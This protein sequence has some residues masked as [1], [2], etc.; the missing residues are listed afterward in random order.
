MVK[1]FK[2]LFGH[3]SQNQLFSGSF[4]LMLGTTFANAGGYLYHLLMGRMLGPAGYGTLVSLIS[5]LYLISVATTTLE[6]V[7]V[8][9]VSASRARGDHK[10]IYGLFVS[11]YK[12]L[13]PL[14]VVLFILFSVFNP[15]FSNF[16][17]LNDSNTRLALFVVGITLL[18]K[19]LFP[20]NSGILRGSLNFSFLSFS[21]ALNIIF[22]IGIGVVLVQMGFSVLGAMIGIV[23]ADFL[24]YFVSF[25]PIKSIFQYRNADHDFRFKNNNLKFVPI[26]ITTLGLTSLFSIDI[27]L[28]KHFFSPTEAGLYSAIAALGKI[29]VFASGVIPMVMLPLT[30][31]KHEKGENSHSVLIQSLLLVA[32]MSIVITIIYFIFPELMIYLLYGNSYI[33]AAPLLGLFAIFISFYSIINVL[34][35]FFLSTKESLPSYLILLGAFSQAILIILFH[36]TISSVIWVSILISALLMFTLLLYYFIN[37]KNQHSIR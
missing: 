16:L 37:G 27:V 8:R 12:V 31:A 9:Y 3:I 7:V 24:S 30:V 26:F 17:N 22:R 2:K 33:S 34:A 14:S 21:S 13:L 29:V 15:S 10:A 18:D 35:N 20:I 19:I 1:K 5:L 25:I 28:V 4:V 11:F 6:T 32:M 23:A 36:Q